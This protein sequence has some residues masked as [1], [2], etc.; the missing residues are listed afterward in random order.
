MISWYRGL[1]SREK[2]VLTLGGLSLII[3]LL[4]VLMD[5]HWAATDKLRLRIL[6]QEKTL[7]WMQQAAADAASLVRDKPKPRAKSDKSLL[8]LIDASAKKAQLASALKRIQP[9]GTEGVKVW[10]EKTEFSQMMRWLSAIERDLGIS[11]K[12]ANIDRENQTG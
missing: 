12:T 4:F 7:S 9:V 11:I 6:E 1:A 2:R 3:I 8:A 5:Q 10:L